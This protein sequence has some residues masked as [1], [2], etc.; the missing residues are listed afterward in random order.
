MSIRI[1]LVG[2][3][4]VV[5]ALALLL[6]SVAIVGIWRMAGEIQ[7]YADA[8]ATRG[9]SVDGV[10]QSMAT[11]ARDSAWLVT[12]LV[13][14]IA[15]LIAATAAILAVLG[16]RDILR[17]VYAVRRYAEAAARGEPAPTPTIRSGDEFEHMS[18]A[19]RKMDA[20]LS[21]IGN[22][23]QSVA[24][25][26]LDAQIRPRSPN[27]ILGNALDAMAQNLR[28]LVG[29]ASQAEAL[30]QAEESR[31][32]LLRLVSHELRTPIGLIKGSLSSITA[33]DIDLNQA[34]QRDFVEIAEAETDRLG[35]LVND[36]LTAA[37][38][39]RAMLAIAP[40]PTDVSALIRDIAV[41][42]RLVSSLHWLDVDG[43]DRPVFAEVDPRRLRQVVGNL[44]DNAIKYS[45]EGGPVSLSLKSDGAQIA[46]HVR[47][48]GI[49]IAPDAQSRVF[50][51]FFR[52]DAKAEGV[53]HGTGLG[54]T[55]V[56]GIV[57]AHR[58]TVG[59]LSELGKGSTFTVRVPTTR[60]QDA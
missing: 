13:I 41:Q 12:F 40:E 7:I 50:D 25:G 49:G 45:P 9:A 18:S 23:A 21:E 15:L 39:D 1:K 30:R 58:G 2:A 29:Q 27:D 48:C 4:A 14:A 43:A 47:D 32:R 26:N 51:E 28:R 22:Y 6:A 17:S 42:Y 55:V 19:L 16:V 56:K 33:G 46:I 24:A 10:A 53:I 8:A 31:R 3:H 54:L 5:V 36:L 38:L 52:V 59:V 20:Y 37:Q 34:S 57:E 44:L 11:A 35:A 60:A